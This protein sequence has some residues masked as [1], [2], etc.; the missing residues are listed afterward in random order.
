M[1]LPL[2]DFFPMPSLL[3]TSSAHWTRRDA[4]GAVPAP[5]LARSRSVPEVGMW[6][7]AVDA[8]VGPAAVVVVVDDPALACAVKLLSGPVRGDMLTDL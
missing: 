5:E 8:E 2:D 1:A 6:I 3:T 7:C 4:S